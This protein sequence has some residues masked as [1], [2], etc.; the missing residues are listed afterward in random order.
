MSKFRIFTITILLVLNAILSTPAFSQTVEWR[1]AQTWPK[2]SPLFGEA[3]K[4]MVTYADKLSQGRLKIQI[5]SSQEHRKPQGIF[6][7]VQDGG[8][9]EMGHSASYFWKDRDINMVFFTT[10]P[11]GMTAVEQYSWFYNAGG[12]ELMTEA[13]EKHGLMS[14]PGG[15]TGNQMGGWFTKEVK[16][17][18]DLEGMKMSIPGLAGDVMASLGVETVDV[19]PNR[20][21]AELKA[22]NIDAVEWVG[23]SLDLDFKFHQVAPFYYTGWNEPATELQFL[24]NQKAFASLS[25]SLQEILKASMRLAGFETYFAI[26][27]ANINNLNRMVADF[28]D[29]KIRA[30]P[31]S[32]IKAFQKATADRI[33]DLAKDGDQL[34]G[35]IVRS[36]FSYKDKARLWTRISDQSYLNN[37]GL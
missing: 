34:T 15:N 17:V 23:P 28:P 29:I 3:V 36:L 10:L 6:E 21:L 33:Y 35:E 32:V 16:S 25:P 18:K 30:F 37:T 22:G 24:V 19:A 5:V 11:F 9:F 7:L 4:K 31:P 1:L 13:Y 2:D 26:N 8:G 20:L 12:L 14:F 27:H